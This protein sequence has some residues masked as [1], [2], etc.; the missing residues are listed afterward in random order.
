MVVVPV[1]QLRDV[2]H[3]LDRGGEVVELEDLLDLVALALPVAE[4]VE[5]LFDL[6]IAQQI[7]HF[8]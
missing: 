4:L 2:V 8:S 5:T 7:G 1:R 3:E 6:F